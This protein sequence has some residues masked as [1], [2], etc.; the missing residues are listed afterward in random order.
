MDYKL[1]GIDDLLPVLTEGFKAVFMKV[2]IQRLE[3]KYC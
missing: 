1:L 2:K 3:G